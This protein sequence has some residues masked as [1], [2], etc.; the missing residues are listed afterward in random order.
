MSSSETGP[1]FQQ[2]YAEFGAFVVQKQGPVEAGVF[3]FDE[4]DSELSERLQGVRGTKSGP[5]R[6][7]L[8]PKLASLGK[9]NRLSLSQPLLSPQIK[10][11]PF[12]LQ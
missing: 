12:P 6:T 9:K 1:P 4:V 2:T 10:R 7:F 8:Q 11:S 5:L 3:L